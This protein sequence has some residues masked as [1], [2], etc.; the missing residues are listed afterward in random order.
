MPLI[1]LTT[2]ILMSATP[3]NFAPGPNR[4][5]VR[6]DHCLAGERGACAVSGMHHGARLCT[7]CAV[8]PS[9]GA[10]R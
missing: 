5:F 2:L 4:C 6:V 1:S 8:T 3:Q 9:N 10:I 7:C